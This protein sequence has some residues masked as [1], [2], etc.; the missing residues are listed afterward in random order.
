MILY[1]LI[2]F[3]IALSFAITVLKKKDKGYSLY[4]DDIRIPDYEFH[5]LNAKLSLKSGN[6]NPYKLRI[7]RS[8]EQAK[9][10]IKRYGM[11][12]FISFD[13]DLG[14][15]DTSIVFLRWL[16]EHY[17]D[18][19]I[20]EYVVHSANPIGKDNLISIMNSWKKAKEIK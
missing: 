8:S 6:K 12:S 15:E 2:S 3:S 9:E 16:T 7:A 20:P 18:L 5:K 1:F 4:L 11:P 10:I 13:H 14:G 19:N 17:F